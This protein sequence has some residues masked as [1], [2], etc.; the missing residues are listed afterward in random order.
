MTGMVGV[1]PSGAV[2]VTFLANGMLPLHIN[3]K[4]SKNDCDHPDLARGTPNS[5]EWPAIYAT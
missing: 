2:S 4:E 3:S 1:S 5:A